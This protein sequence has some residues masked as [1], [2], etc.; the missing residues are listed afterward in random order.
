MSKL[1]NVRLFISDSNVKVKGAGIPGEP[2][3]RR[4]QRADAR[5]SIAAI[6]DAAVETLRDRTDASMDDVA[7]AAGVSRQTVYA[8]FPSRDALLAAVLERAVAETTAAIDVTGLDDLA[9]RDALVRLLDAGWRVA[10]R[11][12]VLW[13]LPSVA[14]QED[15][16][17][18]A[19]VLDPLAAIIRRGQETG[20]FD[21]ALPVS[22]LLSAMLALGRTAEDEVKA[23]RMN[24][25]DATRAVHHSVLRLLGV[26]PGD[27]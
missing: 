25:D 15:A 3:R 21:A 16:S 7:R 10:A 19:P 13:H 4:R 26:P 18:H 14:E 1:T 6:M 2:V 11:Y 9:P 24:I 12:P 8:H 5:Q 27:R 23:G 22:Y 17:R 20:D